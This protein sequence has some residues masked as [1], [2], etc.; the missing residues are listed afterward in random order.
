MVFSVVRVFFSTA[1]NHSISTLVQNPRTEDIPDFFQGGG[2]EKRRLTEAMLG[3]LPFVHQ[4]DISFTSFFRAVCIKNF[5]LKVTAHDVAFSLMLVC[6]YKINV[7]LCLNVSSVVLIVIPQPNEHS[8]R[9]EGR[10]GVIRDVSAGAGICRGHVTPSGAY[11]WVKRDGPD[12]NRRQRTGKA[13][14]IQRGRVGL[15]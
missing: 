8:Q 4:A 15:E 2:L 3:K 12:P 11:T 10:R 7:F 14:T 9:T 5:G 6:P 13:S 1:I